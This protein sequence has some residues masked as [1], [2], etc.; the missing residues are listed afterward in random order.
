[1]LY[2]DDRTVPLHFKVVTENLKL[3]SEWLKHVKL[4]LNQS[5]KVDSCVLQSRK[6]SRNFLISSL[7]VQYLSESRNLLPTL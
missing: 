1:M 7:A 3:A 6:I 2:G 5:K 4:L